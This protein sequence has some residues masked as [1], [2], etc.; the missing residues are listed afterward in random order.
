MTNDI[1]SASF[2]RLSICMILMASAICPYRAFAQSDTD[3]QVVPTAPLPLVGTTEPVEPRRGMRNGHESSSTGRVYDDEIGK[4]ARFDTLK[5]Q[6]QSTDLPGN[7]DSVTGDVGSFR[8]WLHDHQMFFRGQEVTTIS[9]NVNSG[10]QP[11]APQ[12]YNGQKTT[13]TSTLQAELSYRLSQSALDFSQINVRVYGSRVN[14]APA[15][16]NFAGVGRIDYYRTFMNRKIELSVGTGNNLLNFIGIFAGGN[17][18]ISSGVS[19]TIPVEVG[20]SGGNTFLP[21]LNVQVNGKNGFYTKTGIQRSSRPEGA[22]KDAMTS[23]GGLRLSAPGS[24]PLLIQEVGILRPAAGN[25]RQ[26]WV[27]AGGLYNATL[28][29]RLDGQGEARNWAVFALADYQLL[30][31]QKQE[32]H[33][34]L[35]LGISFLAAPG[36]LNVY[37]TTYEVRA[38]GAGIVPGRPADSVNLTFNYNAFSRTAGRFADP[39]VVTHKGQISA[40]MLYAWHL[41]RGIYLTPSVTYIRNPAFAG[42]FKPAI[43]LFTAVN[44]LF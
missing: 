23:H 14:W 11:T 30:Q 35:F 41:R 17:S 39:A 44:I 12:V 1:D 32:P 25:T 36:G 7:Y 38:Y 19:A 29:K 27:R 40:S 16:P 5:P 22:I 4:F 37:K 13:W 2:C 3:G 31:P 21:T 42:D 18:I 20:L 6:G 15:G 43:N 10:R 26:V 9:R 34:G 33:R 28:Y 24:R 8:S